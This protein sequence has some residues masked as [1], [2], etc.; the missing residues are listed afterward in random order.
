[1]S[2]SNYIKNKRVERFLTQKE[3][4]EF[5]GYKQSQFLSNLECGKRK[6]PL[7]TLKK[8]CELYG[9]DDA[10]MRDEYIKNASE[11]ATQMAQHKWDANS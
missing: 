9:V 2:I 11:E 4:S 6:P 8:M 3:A 1:M 7:N 5:L 10:E